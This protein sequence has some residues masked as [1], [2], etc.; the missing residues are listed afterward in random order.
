MNH[1]KVPTTTDI[2]QAE[3]T[4]A[5][6]G[7]SERD[8]PAIEHAQPATPAI[9][10]AQSTSAAI[11][12][13][14]STATAIERVERNAW[15]DMY[16]AAPPSYAAAQGLAH[17]LQDTIGLLACRSL[18]IAEFNRALSVGVDGSFN[19]TALDAAR[20][21][22]RLHGTADAVLQCPP[23]GQDDALKAWLL[24]HGLERRGNGWA[25]FLRATA[26][27]P[28]SSHESSS[29]K[30]YQSS[31]SRSHRS[32]HEGSNPTGIEVRL[33]TPESAA[34]FGVVVQA[35]FGLPDHCAPWFAALAGR[36]GWQ[37]YLAYQGETAIASGALFLQDQ[38]GWMGI[39]ATLPDYRGRGAQSALIARRVSDGI[40]AGVLG[41]TAET[42]QPTGGQEAA[43]TSYSNYRRGGF[44]PVY[45][46]DN[47]R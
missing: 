35:G 17:A 22:L 45:I 42:G 46:R 38:W 40:A 36:P 30:S 31:N 23:A 25:K 44:D 13:A 8:T 27:V 3:R 12:R 26:P 9:E 6:I 4:F 32:A 34:Q 33:V 20:D 41:L 2:R 15:L 37:L 47:Y 11:E 5:A 19:E 14:Q 43:H 21:W 28:V 16:Q 1:R 18:P 7:Q 39:D 24:R 10:R 29:A